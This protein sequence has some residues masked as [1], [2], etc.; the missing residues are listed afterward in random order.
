[1]KNLFTLILILGLSQLLPLPSLAQQAAIV[2]FDVKENLSQNGKL[3]IIAVDT[4]AKTNNNI[5]GS[6]AF[7]INGFKQDLQFT[8]GVA[9][10]A[11][12]IESSTFVFFKH[13]EGT[14]ELGKL[15]FLRVT[16][17]GISPYKISGFLLIIIPLLILYIAYKFKRFLI[18]LLVLALV[19]LYLNYSKG[20]DVKQLI[21]SSI[22]GLKELI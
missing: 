11:N 1:M 14:K 19:Y 21:E 10:T 4:A 18:T 13:V 15:Y 6:Y 7:T 9:V 12:P 22:L 3:A 16:E 8:D 17:K 5:Q 20:L 2:D